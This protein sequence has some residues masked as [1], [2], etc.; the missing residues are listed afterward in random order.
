MSLSIQQIQGP[1]AEPLSIALAKQ[2]CRVDVSDDD[3]LIAQYIV[4][5]RAAVEGYIQ[6]AIF[7]QT[8]MRTLDSFPVSGYN[9]VLNPAY[10]TSWATGAAFYGAATIELP[11][12]RTLAVQSITYRD[13]DGELQTLDPAAYLVDLTSEPARI[14]PANNAA[15][16][17]FGRYQP[18]SVRIT[19]TAGTYVRQQTDQLIVPVAVPF[20]VQLSQPYLGMVSL[21]DAA[22]K[23][24]APSYVVSAQ[25]LVNVPSAY[26]GQTLIA[27]YY[28]PENPMGGLANV[29]SAMM[30]IVGHLYNNREAVSELPLKE[31]PMGAL[32]FLDFEKFDIAGY[33]P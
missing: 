20:Q 11:R 32:R 16:P 12:P 24:I 29:V 30:L 19:Y 23:P 26:Y 4:N 13:N 27:Q 28:T 21:T 17:L 9:S 8:W 2:Q 25:G 18:G 5:A 6:R 14:V 1:L 7:P 33:R 31:I 15:W 22:Q 10:L 3:A